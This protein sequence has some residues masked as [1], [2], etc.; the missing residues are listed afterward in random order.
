M[1]WEGDRVV[2]IAYTPD[3][4]GKLGQEDLEALHDHGFPVPLSQLPE[5]HGDLRAGQP[6][7]MSVNMSTNQSGQ[8]V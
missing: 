7:M 6:Q 3:C 5:Y 4:L 1:D 8:C 2:I